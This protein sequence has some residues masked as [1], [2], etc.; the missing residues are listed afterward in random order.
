MYQTLLNK[1]RYSSNDKIS[2]SYLNRLLQRIIKYGLKKL[3][4]LRAAAA[5]K[6]GELVLLC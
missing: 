1:I 4:Q 3:G 6:R 2:V 5:V